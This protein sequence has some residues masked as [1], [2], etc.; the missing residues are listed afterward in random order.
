MIDDLTLLKQEILEV[1]SMLRELIGELRPV[2][3]DEFGIGSALDGFIERY[4]RQ[5]GPNIPQIHMKID[6]RL[7][8]LPD[9]I[10]ICLFRIF[11]EAFRNSINHAQA[12]NIYVEL[13]QEEGD[14]VLK[15]KDDG[16]GFQVPNH[17]GELSMAGHYGLV[18]INERVSWINGKC[19]IS[20]TPGKGTEVS[21]RIK[22]NNEKYH[23]IGVKNG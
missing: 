15:I 6:N 14:I 2:G 3:L 16:S 5:V 12:K 19:C 7:Q 20:S 21:V 4:R 8:N 17:L 22:K 1:S 13:I 9:E 11:Q 18:G 10:A 23:N